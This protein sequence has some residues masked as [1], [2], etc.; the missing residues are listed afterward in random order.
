[1]ICDVFL[2][3]QVL[4][5]LEVSLAATLLSVLAG[6]VVAWVLARKRFPG[7]SLLEGLAI[8]PL[9]LPPTV[10]GYYLLVTFADASPVGR[11]WRTITGSGLVFSFEGIVL[12]A[13]ITSAPLYIMHAMVA[14]ASVDRDLEDAARVVGAS[15]WTVFTRVTL[16]AAARGVMAG[17]VLAFARALGD[18]GATLMVGGSIPG[19]T[20]TLPLAVYD[21]WQ[22]GEDRRA[23]GLSLLLSAIALG[24][25]VASASLSNRRL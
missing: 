2:A 8:L 21:A 3:D 5:S 18:F 22:Q 19:R 23:L 24:V 14:F 1:M 9:T 20:R 13:A 11:L 12:A 7:R 25:A 17:A 16:P 10:L 6:S 15:E 4:L